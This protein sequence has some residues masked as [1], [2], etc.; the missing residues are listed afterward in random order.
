MPVFRVTYRPDDGPDG[1]CPRPDDLVEADRIELE[2]EVWLVFRRTVFVIG[3]PRD[4]VVRRLPAAPVV[5][6]AQVIA[7]PAPDAA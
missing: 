5:G 2:S 3:T 7:C 1:P 4:V 6:V